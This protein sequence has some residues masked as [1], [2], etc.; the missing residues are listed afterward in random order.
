MYRTVQRICF[1]VKGFR[2]WY[3]RAKGDENM[4]DYTEFYQ[5]LRNRF[6]SFIDEY[7]ILPAHN[8]CQSIYIEVANEFYH[9]DKP[10]PVSHP[11]LLIDMIKHAGDLTVP[12]PSL[13]M[14]TTSP[15]PR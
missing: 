1:L 5:A 13:Q 10:Y 8:I 7:N 3:N 6:Q 14:Q 12:K 11:D 15:D 2:A 9:A 4:A